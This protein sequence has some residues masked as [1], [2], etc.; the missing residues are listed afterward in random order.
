M[1]GMAARNL[2]DSR[3]GHTIQADLLSKSV[4]VR[5]A[6]P[7]GRSQVRCELQPHPDG[8]VDEALERVRKLMAPELSGMNAKSRQQIEERLH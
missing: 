6:A 8:A 3:G 1:T 4:M 2:L 5:V 7:P